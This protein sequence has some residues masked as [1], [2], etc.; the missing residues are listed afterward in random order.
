MHMWLSRANALLLALGRAWMCGR[1]LASRGVN[2][3]VRSNLSVYV[4]CMI[5]KDVFAQTKRESTDQGDFFL[6]PLI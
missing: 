1:A 4:L 3:C 6:W 5:G 2:T